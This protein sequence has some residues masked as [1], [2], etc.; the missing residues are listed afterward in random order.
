MHAGRASAWPRELQ[1]SFYRS[2]RRIPFESVRQGTSY[3][4]VYL[5]R[6]RNRSPSGAASCNPMKKNREVH[7]RK[8]LFRHTL[9]NRA[10]LRVSH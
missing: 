2:N 8:P 6:K 10:L 9:P 1:R 3:P 5:R 4:D 7:I